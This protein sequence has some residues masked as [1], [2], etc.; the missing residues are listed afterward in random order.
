MTTVT[1]PAWAP[2]T[3]YYDSAG[4]APNMLAHVAGDGLSVRFKL[5]RFQLSLQGDQDAPFAGAVGLSGALPVDV[6]PSLQ[7]GC[8]HL[9]ARVSKDGSR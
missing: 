9:R 7:S 5:D 8:L 1:A 3:T 2:W 4:Q 6:P